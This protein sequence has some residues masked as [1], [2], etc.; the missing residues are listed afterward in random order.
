MKHFKEDAVTI[1]GSGGGSSKKKQ[2][3]PVEQPNTLRAKV[4]GRIL[5]L[6]AYGPIKGLVN[7]LKSVYLDDTPV[8]NED[9]STNFQ[10]ITLTTRNGTPDQDYI[11]GFRTVENTIEVN[12][13]VK[14]ATP[15]IRS[16]TNND[17]DAVA[18]TVQLAG[19]VQQLDNGDSVG[20]NV[21][22]LIEVRKD[23]GGWEQAVSYTING[24]T[25]S[26]Y[27]KTFRIDLKHYGPG[28]FDIRVR[29]V[30]QE[31]TSSKLQD[32][33]TWTL[34]TE[35]IDRRF[36]Y[37]NM[38]LV[39]ID[40]DSELFGSQMPARSYDMYLSETQ[41]P[42]NWDPETRVYT[43]IWD[44]TFKEAYHDN[45]A[46]AYYDLATHP[47]IGAGLESV[48]KWELYR[49]AQ[50]C[51]ALVPDGYGDMEPRFTINTV[52]SA[53]EDA[54]TA[55]N[56]LANV[57][58]GMTYWGNNTVIPVADMPED[59]VLTVGP[60]SVLE[61]DFTYAGTSIRERHSV[62]VVMWNDPDDAGKPVPEVYEDPI[63]IA[64]YGWRETRVTAV[65]CNSRGQARRMAMW[66]LDSERHETQTMS[67]TGTSEHA[68]LRPGNI[69]EVADPFV[70]GARMSGRLLEVAANQVRLDKAPTEAIAQIGGTWYLSV[71]L[72]DLSLSRH[73]VSSVDGDVIHLVDPLATLPLVGAIWGMYSAGLQLPYYR[74]VSNREDQAT[75]M[76]QITATEYDPNKYS[77]VELGLNIP[78]RPIS[79]LP[80]G[81]IPSPSNLEFQVYTY[82]AGS[83]RH[84]GLL[85]SWEP[86]RDVRVETFV[87]DVKDPSQA[88]FRTVYAG[89]GVSFD[90][91]DAEAGNWTIR[92][93]AVASTGK[94]SNWTSRNVQ[95][96]QLL[97][98]S[99]PD[100]VT[101]EVATFSITLTP[102]S[103]YP[104]AIWEFWRST[105]ALS[106]ENIETNAQQL[107]TGNYLVDAN[108]KPDTQYYYY[109]RGTNQYGKSTWFGVQGKTL[110]NFDDILDAVL[111][112]VTN[113]ELFELINSQI[114]TKATQI[115]ID[116][117]N[118]IVNQAMIG[119]NEQ[120]TLVNTNITAIEGE[121]TDL[122]S[123]VD[124][125][126]EVVND[127][128]TDLQGQI[129]NAIDAL[130]YLNTNAYV[131]GNFVKVGS[132][133]YQ[134]KI[135]VPADPTNAK[136]PPNGT[137]W[138]DAGSVISSAD[139]LAA[140]VTVNEASITSIN[141]TLTAQATTITGI[142]ST[143][144]GKA[145]ASALT[146][147]TTRV[148]A[149]EGL[150]T[151]QGSAIT[152]LTSTVAGKA[153]SS[154][155]NALTTRVTAAEGTITSQGSALTSLTS[156]VNNKA[157]ASAVNALTTRVTA[158]EGT[159]VSQ[160]G[161]I[162]D[163]TSA[164]GTKADASALSALTTRVST[165]EGTLTSQGS[166]I[167]S[168]SNTLNT[169]SGSG[170][171]LLVD[172]YSWLSS[173]VLPDMETSLVTVAG[174]AIAGSAS[175]FGIRATSSSNNTAQEFMLVPFNS[176]AGW[177][178]PL[179]AGNYLLSFYASSATAA[180]V[181]MAL[182]DG[183]LRYSLS[184]A[185]TTTRTRYTLLITIPAATKAGFTVYP[186]MLGSASI[187]IL[188]DSFMIEKQAGNGVVGSP[189]VAG[190]SAQAVAANSAAL[191]G[192]TTRVTAAEG[193]ITSQA[194]SLVSLNSTINA[195]GGT[196]TN[197][198]PAEY[199]SFSSTLPPI[200]KGPAITVASETDATSYSGSALKITSAATGSNY[201]Y[202]ADAIDDFNMRLV[203]GGKYIVS[204]TARADV[205]KLMRVRVRAPNSGGSPI[206][207]TLSDVSVT[208]TATRFSFLA[209]MPAAVVDRGVLVFYP[210]QP[211]AA[212]TTYLTDIM[213]EK[214][215]GNSVN[216]SEF[217]PGNSAR[218]D[219]VSATAISSMDTRVTSAEGTITSHTGSI[220][221]LT[222]SIAGKA[223]ASALSLLSGTVTTQ[224][225]TIDSHSGQLTS[226]GNIAYGLSTENLIS[227]PTFFAGA[228]VI[229]NS[230]T[231][232][233][234]VQR[235]DGGVPAG[236]PTMRLGKLA[237]PT[238][239]GNNY[240]RFNPLESRKD[241][242]TRLSV[243][244]GEVYYFSIDVYKAGSGG[245]Q[246]GL[247]AQPYGA[248]SE[249]IDHDWMVASPVSI[250]TTD[251]AW[252][253]LNGM[254]TIPAGANSI[255]LNLRV[256]NGNA[257][258][259]YFANPK[260]YKRSAEQSATSTAIT[261]LDSR[262]GVTEGTLTSQGAAITSLT[263]TVNVVG[264][265]GSNL[266]PVEYC[267]F[268]QE[269]LPPMATR[270]STSLS[271]LLNTKAYNGWSLMV[272]DTLTAAG[273]FSLFAH[274]DDMNLR[275]KP[276][277]KYIVSFW[278]M[279]DEVRTIN[280][281]LRFVNAAGTHVEGVVGSVTLNPT[282]QR[283][284]TVITAPSTVVDE[285]EILF[286]TNPVSVPSSSH[287]DGF[288][289]E[290]QVGPSTQPSSFVPGSATTAL[291]A[292]AAAITSL[293]T[294]VTSAEGTI[295][296]QAGAVT[297]IQASLAAGGG[298]GSN[299]VPDTYSWPTSTTLPAVVTS[300]TAPTLTLIGV[301]VAAAQSGFGFKTTSGSTATTLWY[302]LCPSN[303]ASGYNMALE[304]GNYMVSYYASAPG[305]ARMQV[306]LYDG[307]AGPISGVQIL[308][309]TRTR[310]TAILNV[311]ATMKAGLMIYPNAAGINGT[312]VTVDSVMVEKM[313]SGATT[314]APSPFVA[315]PAAERV[316][317]QASAISSMD[318]RVTSAEGTI[319]SQS[320]S[321]TSLTSR[322]GTA[323]ANI[324]T[325]ATTLASTNGTLTS[326]W[327]MK[328]N[329]N[330]NG[331]NFI[332]GMGAG[333]TTVGGITQ[334]EILFQADRFALLN[335]STNGIQMPFFIESG[336]TYITSAMI[337][338]ASI[339]AAQI[340]SAQINTGHIG[341]AQIIT[342]HIADAQ[343]TN[344]K[345][346]SL[347]V[348]TLKIAGN[349]VTVPV[350]S[351]TTTPSVTV[352]ITIDANY[353]IMVIGSLTQANFSTI[354]LKRNGVQLWS[355]V[356]VAGTVCC[357]G[358]VDSPGAGT[359]TYVL[360]STHSGNVN[361]S[362]LILLACKK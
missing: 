109:V 119:V 104:E 318:T 171:N 240:I 295:T 110:N 237:V 57:F 162:T 15:V 76:Y 134:A 208:T 250:S 157:D 26:P 13:E 72:P 285:A 239:A 152:S 247:W 238:I 359:H 135:D 70:Q 139:G 30:T 117:A 362:S 131:A 166:S 22:I 129:D 294:R 81:L 253:T 357:R 78:E 132:S 99:P 148:T 231:V 356:P 325:T 91:T 195:L 53:Q 18:V 31:S 334:S 42:S 133:L 93:R 351:Y 311:P 55:L 324:T 77:R 279:A 230:G 345:I 177:N 179:E 63:S 224:G 210:T 206:E 8:E 40:V 263:N 322:V 275:M 43:G 124:G 313:N 246:M 222:N 10:G 352:V 232:A 327:A 346:G 272:T 266:V 348:D 317:A 335:T 199:S 28:D 84:Q 197:L 11:P 4:R 256:S 260:L 264:G 337:K 320:S 257:V 215:V 113:G 273:Y 244:G 137:Y 95:I 36:S 344:A 136:A 302:L 164:V 339:M 358:I 278:G 299:L 156:T 7:G 288:M 255:N 107:P 347:A 328:I 39:G 225:N 121:I 102:R 333:I 198:V 271:L 115:A 14:L 32:K 44:G 251:N 219:I 52:F 326:M 50:Y 289:V 213:V 259:I 209:T 180:T 281:R 178:L 234:V 143:L 16:L 103:A 349:A 35:I 276:L 297:A 64:E 147:L 46:W 169:L 262:V 38:A 154:A 212:G 112:D 90:L 296:S 217:V 316:T 111:E 51:D 9:G 284:S 128:L 37:P 243:I 307:A 73:E 98:P 186:N 108:L 161:A 274:I 85:I 45:P 144:N 60:G 306:R 106:A 204:F 252:V 355:E 69:I 97:L 245:R 309:T 66:I 25:T 118:A 350:A 175:G 130:E 241:A 34:I 140:R 184:Q 321:I 354:S 41:V 228:P 138:R 360:A 193:T 310:Y 249:I 173:L 214:Q 67:Y 319:T 87:L 150:I 49:I 159:I 71:M 190:P 286:Y 96:S 330:V 58:R 192:L 303:G 158:A 221:T 181:R 261:A 205:A 201:L 312:Q 21:P 341:T 79:L 265:T 268:K 94:L 160:S 127:T 5:D 88:G 340:A 269:G 1:K 277:Q 254:V 308:T 24:K 305:A 342:A 89:P 23:G 3:T 293:T 304:P 287:F 194:G 125:Q 101:V 207:T 145:D 20:Y 353:P 218:A 291:T 200:Y 80:T 229:V 223:D 315:G 151:S 82:F 174:V 153:D 47:I 29:R 248:A 332:A 170:T 235:T 290:E 116:E 182:Y 54:I 12:A 6:I 196:G 220:T 123:D 120:L 142:Q 56:T 126:L 191:T 280:I 203:P 202:L 331:K 211:V 122:R 167:T 155:L 270:V 27:P 75:G 92:V 165:A 343:I 227:D 114:D 329:T 187:N 292:T 86:P 141:G 361:G 2:H 282:W 146:S 17:A 188:F 65:G 62:A 216:P 176:A 300:S 149:A 233:T 185:L 189:F 74:V 183:V 168:L 105:V 314:A 59:P 267:T 336:I 258:T 68:F 19:L 301:A 163:L 323:E 100:S 172:T 236:G 242:T 226:L 48:D 338:N 33:L 298:A 283:V 61:G 83:S